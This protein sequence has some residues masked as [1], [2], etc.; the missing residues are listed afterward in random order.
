VDRGTWCLRE[1]KVLAAG[2][3]RT[4]S[5]GRLWDGEGALVASM[6]TQCIL[7]GRRKAVL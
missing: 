2:R 7:R 1:R 5:E 6:T 3:G 4:Y